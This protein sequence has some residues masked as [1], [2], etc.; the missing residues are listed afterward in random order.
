MELQCFTPNLSAWKV[1]DLY[2]VKYASMRSVY[3]GQQ[4]NE[5]KVGSVDTLGF[6]LLPVA[7][8]R[9]YTS[10]INISCNKS[11]QHCTRICHTYHM[12]TNMA[13]TLC[14]VFLKLKVKIYSS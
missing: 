13:Y 12:E 11:R 6:R 9:I 1:D 10:T 8:L 5:K 14:G 7:S 3:N 2:H 4:P